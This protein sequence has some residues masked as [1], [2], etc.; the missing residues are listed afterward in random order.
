MAQAGTIATAYVQVLPSTKGIGSNLTKQMQGPSTEAGKSAGKSLGSAIKG[1]IAKIGI[2]AAVVKTF[3]DTISEGAKLQ[4]SYLG[5]LDTIYKKSADSMQGYADAAAAYGMSANDYAEQAVGF[6]A[7]LKQAF[8]GDTQKAAESANTA[9][10]DMADNAAK[11]GTD[12]GS[13]QYAYQGFAKQNYTMLDNLKL[14]YGGTKDEMERLLD[15]AQKIT[16]VKYDISNLGDVYE[17]IHVI[18]GQ[19]G[20]TGVAADEAKTTVSGSFDAMKASAKDL[21]GHLALG[22][23]I[24]PQL[25]AFGKSV[26]TYLQNLIPM[27]GNILKTV[28]E[29]AAS[30][31]MTGIKNLPGLM[32]KAADKLSGL[33]DLISGVTGPQIDQVFSSVQGKVGSWISGTFV[34]FMQQSF[35][36]ALQ[37]LGSAIYNAIGAFFVTILPQ[38]LSMATNGIKSLISQLSGVTSGD[39]N[40]AVTSGLNSIIST[41]GPWITGTFFPYMKNTLLPLLGQLGLMILEALGSLLSNIWSA[42]TARFP[43]L[44]TIV[45]TIKNIIL[46][47]VNVI[48]L[49]I[50]GIVAT[51]TTIVNF[52]ISAWDLIKSAVSTAASVVMNVVVTAWNGIGSVTATVWNAISTVTSIVWNSVK[53]VITTVWNGIKSVVLPVASAIKSGISDAWNGIKSVVTTVWNAISTATTTVWN[54]IKTA[55]TTAVGAL[56]S[57]VTSAWN[58]IKSITTTVWNGIRSVVLPVANAVKSGVSSAW[59]E[60]RSVTG[61]VWNGIKSTVS[62]VINGIKSTISSG[63]N[64]ALGTVSSVLGSIKSKFT[65]IFDGCRSI[66]TGAIS[67]IKGAFNFSWHLP[68]LALPHIHVSG[69]V[70][71]FGIAGKGSLP[72][73]SVEWYAKGGILKSPTIFGMNGESLMGGG[74]AGPEAVL[75][76]EN[77]RGYI[78]D[79]MDEQPA[80]GGTYTQNVFITSPTALTPSEVARQTRNATRQLALS[81]IGA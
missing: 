9:I 31:I 70:A 74:E 8:G 54:G 58:G 80:G 75:P 38:L 26:I 33:A 66:V 56:K 65:S 19:L 81:M 2:T 29:T 14:G 10:M 49:I 28:G 51:I 57:A 35:L 27:I 36:P 30:A 25:V 55:I 11:M 23:D 4:Q 41:V 78:M 17:A 15:D 50:M 37:K 43:V 46:T 32:S 76:I 44:Q 64:G 39:V 22:D 59:N 62:G 6:G 77:L 71:P 20:I 45:D 79:A 68:K 42:L 21:I 47:A 7:A 72:H 60:I 13:L 69:G 52:V 34:P 67:K 40:T 3:K 73:F 24:K 1:A 48:K 5:G 53:S 16:G 12:V 63:L 61:T 18:Q